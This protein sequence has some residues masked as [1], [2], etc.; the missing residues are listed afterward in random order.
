MLIFHGLPPP[1]MV[2]GA[3]FD[4]KQVLEHPPTRRVFKLKQ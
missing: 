1:A 3:V 4:T 2:A